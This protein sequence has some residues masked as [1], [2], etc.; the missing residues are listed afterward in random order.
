MIPRAVPLANA[1]RVVAAPLD[2]AILAGDAPHAMPAD[3][4]ACARP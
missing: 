1:Q 2:A 4:T 3:M